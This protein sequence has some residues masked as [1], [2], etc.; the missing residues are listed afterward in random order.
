MNKTALL[1][2]THQKL[3]KIGLG[4]IPMTDLEE[5]VLPDYMGFGTTEDEK[6][7]SLADFR[8]LIERQNEQTTGIKVQ[9][10]IQNIHSRIAPHGLSAFMADTITGS[11]QIG[12]EETHVHVRFSV[13][14]EFLDNKW[15]AVHSHGS[16][17]ELVETATDTFGIEEWKQRTEALEKTV[18]ERTAEIVRQKEELEQALKELKSTQA[19]LI[20]SEKLASLGELTAGIA[21]EIQNPLNFVNNFSEV[22]AE[23]VTE[24]EEEQQKPERDPVLEA[25][26][27]GDLKQNL[28]KITHHGGRASTIVKGMLE[29]SRTSTGEKQPTDLNALAD[30]YLRLAYHGLRAKDKSL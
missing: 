17:P 28:Q 19:Q 16:K 24:L 15:I 10:D 2:D 18:A 22:S 26:I 25:E 21:H 27:L 5:I 8:N 23:L 13:M 14:F 11:L 29:H 9:W 6:M 20:Q 30:E 7:F 12:S 1:Q 4:I 3:L